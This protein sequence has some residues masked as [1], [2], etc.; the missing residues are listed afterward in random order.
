MEFAFHAGIG[1][2]SQ[3]AATDK[4]YKMSDASKQHM[5]KCQFKKEVDL[6]ISFETAGLKAW[7]AFKQINDNGWISRYSNGHTK[8]AN[9]V[10]I[11]Q[12]DFHS[13]QSRILHWE[14]FY[15]S[16][17][18]PC[19]FRLLSFN[20]NLELENELDLRR[21]KD[22]D[23]TLVLSQPLDGK[24]FLSTSLDSIAIEKWMAYYCELNDKDLT[25]QA[26]HI[27]MIK[28]I[29]DKYLPAV[30]RKN[31]KVVSC[32]LGVISDGLFGL[33]DIVTHPQCRK[34]GYGTE[35]VSGML[36]WAMINRAHKA[37]VQVVAE[38]TPAVKLYQKLGYEL[39]YKYHYK[40]QTDANT[41]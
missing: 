33:F 32:G 1:L 6:N 37:Y 40:I 31:K 7:P 20:D 24:A 10:T 13:L 17:G 15:N 3:W 23:Q 18:L 39:S 19:I 41:P 27:K 35:M 26:T 30:L 38:N 9:S 8:R 21:Y 25:G 4:D 5:H 14:R 2:F 12:P 34:K 16:Q 28:S 11:L 36:H 22:C 29:T